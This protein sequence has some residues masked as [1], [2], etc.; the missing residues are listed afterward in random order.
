[1][2][3]RKQVDKLEMVIGQ[4]NSLHSELLLLSKKAP[5]DAVNVFKLKFINATLSSCN[6]LFGAKYR[7]YEDFDQFSV[8]DVPSTSDVVFMISQ[9][10]QSVEKMR[11]DHIKQEYGDW[12]YDIEDSEEEV[13]TGPPAKIGT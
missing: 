13:R 6:Q 4:L 12:Y 1:M 5:N 8:D 2:L 7:P 10:L 11:S 3:K 9:Y